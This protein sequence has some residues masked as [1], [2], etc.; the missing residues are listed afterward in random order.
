MPGRVIPLITE[1]TYHVFNRG[2][3]HRRTFTNSKEHTRALTAMTYYQYDNPPVRL[4]TFLVLSLERQR[5]IMEQVREKGTRLVSF[6]TY[7][8]MPNHFHFQLRQLKDGGISRF[9]SNF[10]NSYTR[11][12]NLKHKRT[13]PLFLD[14][15]EARHIATD[16]QQIH[17]HRYIH[18]NPYTGYVVKSL[19]DL[20]NYPWS[21]LPEYLGKTEDIICEKKIIVSQFIDLAAYKKFL[22]DQLDYQRQ[23]DKI[24]HLFIDQ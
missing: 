2:I 16:E 10:Q 19:D 21:S 17:T 9:M 1:Q 14:R 20:M 7:C 6:L 15:F 23:L 11:F 24:K 3:D 4:S 18:I 5:E 22:T 8:F 12:F 13:G